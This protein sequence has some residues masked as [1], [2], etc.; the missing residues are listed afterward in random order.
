MNRE[1]R[2]TRRRLTESPDASIE[3]VAG[4]PACAGFAARARAARRW[5][6][7]HHAGVEP[8]SGFGPSVTARLPRGAEASLAWAALRLL[9]VTLALLLALA[10]LSFE[11]NGDSIDPIPTENVLA[12]VIDRA[13]EGP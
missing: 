11:T 6:R 9:P 1:C 8:G 10:W 5:F 12:W 3:H 13:G 2:R 4:C 7:D